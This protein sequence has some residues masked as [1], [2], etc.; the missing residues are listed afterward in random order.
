MQS[1]GLSTSEMVAMEKSL[2][3]LG[4]EYPSDALQLLFF[5]IIDYTVQRNSISI[6]YVSTY[7]I[8]YI[9][10]YRYYY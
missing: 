1:E 10:I 5:A 9:F 4:F 3:S 6:Y 8:R 2:S 7:Y